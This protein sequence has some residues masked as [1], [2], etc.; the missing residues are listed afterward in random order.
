[1]KKHASIFEKSDNYVDNYRNRR[2]IIKL[3]NIC[4]LFE[5]IKQEK[6]IKGDLQDKDEKSKIHI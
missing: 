2:N 1:M 6:G 3:Y 4:F 5:T